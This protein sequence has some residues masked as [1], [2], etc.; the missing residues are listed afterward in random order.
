MIIPWVRPS[1]LSEYSDERLA[2]VQRLIYFY[3]SDMKGKKHVESASQASD[4]EQGVQGDEN[5]FDSAETAAL[6]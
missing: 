6:A 3:R 1:L 2:P 5:L 4:N